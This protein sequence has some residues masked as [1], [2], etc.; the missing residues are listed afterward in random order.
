MVT[1]GPIKRD[2]VFTCDCGAVLF[3]QVT[4]FTQLRPGS[5]HPIAQDDDPALT[6]QC[7]ACRTVYALVDGS[8]EVVWRTLQPPPAA[9]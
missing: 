2:D 1:T 4:K 9:A 6:I 5:I 3:M 7:A 8:F